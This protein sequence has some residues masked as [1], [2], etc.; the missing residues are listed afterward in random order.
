MYSARTDL[1]RE[2]G[3]A[4]L[5]PKVAIPISLCEFES[6]DANGLDEDWKRLILQG[7]N[8]RE[9]QKL[10]NDCVRS[11]SVGAAK[12]LLVTGHICADT[13]HNIGLVLG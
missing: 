3:S 13:F 7:C 12:A 1:I 11:N 5:L 9:V 4:N 10:L 6:K 8:L 2:I